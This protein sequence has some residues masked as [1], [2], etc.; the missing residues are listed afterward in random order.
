MS[1]WAEKM[2]PLTETPVVSLKVPVVVSVWVTCILRVSG[3][4]PRTIREGSPTKVP[5]PPQVE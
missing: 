4:I 1:V 5:M 3:P 2:I